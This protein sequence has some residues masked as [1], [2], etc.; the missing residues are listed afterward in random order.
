MPYSRY[1][2]HQHLGKIPCTEHQ[3]RLERAQVVEQHE[4]VIKDLQKPLARRG[5]SVVDRALKTR[6][7]AV[8][9]RCL[10]SVTLTDEIES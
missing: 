9:E 8:Y 2:L 1:R 4:A 6:Q 10:A 3:V 7:V 5:E